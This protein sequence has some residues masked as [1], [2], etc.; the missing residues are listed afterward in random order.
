MAQTIRFTHET[1]R[2]VEHEHTLPAR[3]EVCDRC[4]GYGTHLHPAIGG[5]A[6]SPEEFNEAFFED[7]EREAYFTR[8]GRYDVRCE[9]CGGEKVVDVVDVDAAERTLRG[10]RLLALYTARQA[11]R[12]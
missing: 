1:S 4:D 3:R 7:D 8:G 5:H 9:V 6:Y 2:G 11:R 10:R 12:D